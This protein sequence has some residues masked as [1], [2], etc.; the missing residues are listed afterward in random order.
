MVEVSGVGNWRLTVRREAGGVALLRAVTCDREAVLPD[1]LFGLPVVALG[2]RAM[3]PEDGRLSPEGEAVRVTCGSGDGE[4]DNRRMESLTLPP[5]L[6]RVGNYALL[7]CTGLKTLRF[8]DNV[9]S[10]GGG[11]LMNC[12]SLYAFHLTRTG[13][14]QGPGLAYLA[15]EL[16]RE[17]DVTIRGHDGTAA[18]LLFPEYVE[19]YEENIS[20][21]HFDYSIAGAGYP[22]HHCF[23]QKRLRLNEYD[24]LWPGYLAMEHEAE[25]ALRLAWLRLRHP[26]ELSEGAEA[27]YLRYIQTHL[28]Q[29][30]NRLAARGDGE[31]LHFLLRRTSPDR[32]ALSEACA[33][34]REAGASAALAL[35][36]EEQHRRFPAG[37]AKRFAL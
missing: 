28:G 10:W 11:A 2:D 17:L 36:L 7:N 20:A 30:L 26:V 34:A 24:A 23:R 37:A 21:H 1:A 8:H 22:Y 29:A 12:R 5:P 32:A 18:R 27:A 15:G 3:A 9:S 14:D 25:T 31:G 13:P 16:C 19:V 4:W 6:E 33:R 35:L